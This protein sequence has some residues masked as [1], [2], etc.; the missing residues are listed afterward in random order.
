MG[1]QDFIDTYIILGEMSGLVMKG[2]VWFGWHKR[3][4]Y[5]AVRHG[6]IHD[7]TNRTNREVH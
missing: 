1:H 4:R 2:K 7:E 5:G 3:M 6:K